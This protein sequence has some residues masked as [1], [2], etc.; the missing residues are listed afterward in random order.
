MEEFKVERFEDEDYVV[1]GR[2]QIFG[3]VLRKNEAQIVARWLP[4]AIDEIHAMP[5]KEGYLPCCGEFYECGHDKDCYVLKEI[6]AAL[7]FE[8]K[9]LIAKMEAM[10]IPSSFDGINTTIDACIA[11]VKQ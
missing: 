3:R 5:A 9:K 2:G 6:E 8:R 1:L 11:I 4:T 10:K 7:K